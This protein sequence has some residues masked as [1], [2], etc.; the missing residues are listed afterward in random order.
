MSEIFSVET[1]KNYSIEPASMKYLNGHEIL[2]VLE[3][4][5]GFALSLSALEE[6]TREFLKEIHSTIDQTTNRNCF[7]SNHSFISR[8][9]RRGALIYNH[10]HLY[11]EF[12]LGVDETIDYSS[13]NLSSVDSQID[14]F[15]VRVVG[16]QL[17]GD[18]TQFT[19]ERLQ[20][21][22]NRWSSYLN[23]LYKI[24]TFVEGTVEN[25]VDFLMPQLLSESILQSDKSICPSLKNDSDLLQDEL[26]DTDKLINNVKNRSKSMEL[27]E[28]SR[29]KV[30]QVIQLQK[31]VTI[32]GQEV[33]IDYENG[34][35]THISHNSKGN[36]TKNLFQKKLKTY[37][38]YGNGKLFIWFVFIIIAF[39]VGSS[40]LAFLPI[41]GLLGSLLILPFSKIMAIKAHGI[42]IIDPNQQ[43]TEQEQLVYEVVE[44]L[45]YK[46]DIPV[47]QVGI[48]QSPDMNAFA[49]GP[50]HSMAL[51]AL[52]SALLEKL[53][54]DE[55]KAV[56]AHELAH[57]YN[58]DMLAMTF[59]TGI[60]SSLMIAI[61]IPFFLLLFFNRENTQGAVIV[62]LIF[63]F[64]RY[65]VVL[66][67]AF[68]GFLVINAFSRKREYYADSFAALLVGK[69]HMINAL[70]KLDQDVTE[71]PESQNSYATFK[72][73]GRLKL[74]E[75][76]STHPL[77][78]KR[79]SALKEQRYQ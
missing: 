67:V 38:G 64:L 24:N 36:L 79:I 59:F 30:D 20:S 17:D 66:V 6:H 58:R 78:E 47:P 5:T 52:S 27:L 21:L 56:I 57:I 46:I 33:E 51:V 72:I 1:S 8:R 48:Y 3:S 28:E 42:Q 35:P 49:T 75:W 65:I 2:F 37:Q 10:F 39:V 68:I 63:R 13:A 62:D 34:Q 74:S 69:E 25:S 61:K 54:F 11:W 9:G 76:F 18:T 73:S 41:F 23:N 50:N 77:I 40:F 22:L 29:E 32:D 45:A 55:I 7:A 12:S 44:D 43:M 14:Y 16:L 15:Q 19:I 31:Q 71:I 53:D 60:I 26:K 70:K 4:P